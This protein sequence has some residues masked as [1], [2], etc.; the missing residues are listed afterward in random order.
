VY[1]FLKARPVTRLGK[2]LVEKCGLAAGKITRAQMVLE[3]TQLNGQIATEWQ[4][5]FSCCELHS[6]PI[7]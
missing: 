6:A 1:P 7:G 2:L 5:R 3:F 4:H